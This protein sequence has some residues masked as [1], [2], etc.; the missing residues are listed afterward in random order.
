MYNL[1]TVGGWNQAYFMNLP[2]KHEKRMEIQKP[3]QEII[4]AGGQLG[5]VSVNP[6]VAVEGRLYP[7]SRF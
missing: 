2:S 4:K 5:I 6:M 3:T 7:S 1:Q